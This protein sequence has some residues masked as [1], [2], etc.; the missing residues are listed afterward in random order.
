MLQKIRL[1]AL[2]LF[3]SLFIFSSLSQASPAKAEAKTAI[4]V[5]GF[6]TTV[7][8]GLPAI[9]NIVDGV[10]KAYPNTEVRICFTSNIIR[11]VWKKRQENPQKWLS[12]GIPKEVLYVENIIS[13]FG[14]LREDGYRNIIV[15]PTHMFYME[16]SHDLS[17]Y[18][19]ALASIQ[20]MKSK[21]RPYDAV[22]MGRPALGMPGD[23]YSY[24]E[25]VAKA[26]AT[27]AADVALAQKEGAALIY[28]GHGNEHWSTGI[29]AEVENAMNKAYPQVT[30]ILGVVEGQ[31]TLDDVVAKLQRAGIKKVV[32]KPFMIVAGDHARNDMAGAE[33]DSWKS[34]LLE[35]GFKVETV[36]HGLGENDKFAR[37]FVEH[38]ADTAKMHNLQVR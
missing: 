23:I 26:I 21:W 13:V 20:T 25:D 18:V 10:R 30:T 5:A 29:Y 16:Q 36:L 31:P 34:I 37:I 17:Q 4:I 3:L 33:T 9:L 11:K 8:E 2:A 27:L 12:M 15:Q 1:S 24:H 14:D 6:G 38:I 35:K 32:L 7:P 22:F 19:S 28:M